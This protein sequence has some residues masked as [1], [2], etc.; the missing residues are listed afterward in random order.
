MIFSFFISTLAGSFF[1]TKGFGE[2][3]F[4]FSSSAA[5][6]G[7]AHFEDVVSRKDVAQKIYESIT[8]NE[9]DNKFINVHELDYD[10]TSFKTDPFNHLTAN[11]TDGKDDNR[12]INGLSKLTNEMIIKLFAFERN[13]NYT[14]LRIHRV[15]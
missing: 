7:Y 13:I 6:Y 1:L 2:G 14:N 11:S 5:V 4:I 9:Y 12:M 8:T 15:F 10:W 3:K